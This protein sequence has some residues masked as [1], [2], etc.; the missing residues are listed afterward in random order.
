LWSLNNR[1]PLWIRGV[2][3][4][5]WVWERKEQQRE[6]EREVERERWCERD[7]TDGGNG[8]NEV[9]K[10]MLHVKGFFNDLGD[11]GRQC[12]PAN[13][14]AL[15]GY[16]SPE[17]SLLTVKLNSE[18]SVGQFVAALST[19]IMRLVTFAIDIDPSYTS[20][21]SRGILHFIFV[22]CCGFRFC[23]FLLRNPGNWP[24]QS[25]TSNFR[26]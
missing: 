7:G 20:N 23:V 12:G 1:F 22:S 17:I 13:D 25:S 24:T 6:Q 3:V 15:C 18:F 4:C 8:G 2:C 26:L 5:A 21:R 14:S 16:V 19:M 9:G 11:V 10:L